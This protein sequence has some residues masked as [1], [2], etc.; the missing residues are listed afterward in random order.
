MLELLLDATG[1][2]LTG[3]VGGVLGV[4]ASSSCGTCV[5]VIPSSSSKRQFSHVV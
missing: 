3:I 2:G 5:V 4:V 1:A